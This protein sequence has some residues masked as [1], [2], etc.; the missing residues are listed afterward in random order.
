MSAHPRCAAENRSLLMLRSQSQQVPNRSLLMLRSQS[1]Q[2]PN[3]PNLKKFQ[4]VPISKTYKKKR[5]ILKA[6]KPRLDCSTC[7]QY[8]MRCKVRTN[9]LDQ[10]SVTSLL[11]LSLCGPVFVCHK[12]CAGSRFL[13]E[14][15]CRFAE[16]MMIGI[17]KRVHV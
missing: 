5:F 9:P 6:S 10:P 4:A 8:C 15:L 13:Y 3:G 16:L 7:L 12:S 14:Y 17:Y 1:Q 11:W 2:V